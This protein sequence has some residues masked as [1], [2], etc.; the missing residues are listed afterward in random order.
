MDIVF[1]VPTGI[2]PDG[3]F[4]GGIGANFTEND[5]KGFLIKLPGA[6]A[7]Q[8]VIKSEK[9][10]VYPNPVKDIVTIKSLDKIESAEVYSTAGQ[11]VFSSKNIIDNKINLSVLTKGVY[12]LKVQ[13]NKGLQS[14]KLMKN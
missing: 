11:L 3:K 1:A 10:N 9:L 7:S 13:T 12:I 4:I 5:A 14:I 6:L 8:E 2:S